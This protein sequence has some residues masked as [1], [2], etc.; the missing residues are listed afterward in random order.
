M[1]AMRSSLLVLVLVIGAV[2]A[3]A[4]GPAEKSDDSSMADSGQS[5][6]MVSTGAESRYRLYSEADFAAAAD[7]LRVY[8]FHASWCPTCREAE[9]QFTANPSEIPEGVVVFQ[10]DYDQNRELKRE[11]GVTYQHTF[12]AVD[13]QGELVRI[14]QGG[15]LEKFVRN[16]SDLL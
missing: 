15:D 1:R 14:W 10:I 3:W 4:G 7:Q 12:V 5:A 6:M 13:S 8:F 2:G 16:T 9:K 11:F